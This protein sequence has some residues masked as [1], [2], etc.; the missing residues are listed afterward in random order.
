[1]NVL[2]VDDNKNDRKLLS[3]ILTSNN[4]KVNEVSNGIE[5]LKELEGSRPD[6]IISDI[7]M[8]KMDGFT[9]LREL[10]KNDD[11]KDIPFVYYTAYYVSEKDR[12]L[13]MKLGASRYILK[14]KEVKDLLSEIENVLEEYSDGKIKPF[15]PL[16]KSEEEYLTHY[17]ER[18]V[19]KLEEKIS[20]LWDTKNFLNA[21]LDNM[22]DGVMVTDPDLNIIYC[23]KRMKD[24]VSCDYYPGMIKKGAT[25][26]PCIPDMAH[27][28]KKPF[29]V[30][31]LNEE[32]K[33]VYLEGI[34]SPTIN[35]SGN[36]TSHIGVFR[37]ITDFKLSRE[38]I[39][40]K[41]REI[42]I[43]YDIDRMF[44]E[45]LNSDQLIE[46]ALN[47]VMEV[48]DVE[49]GCVYIVDDTSDKLKVQG[50]K[51]LPLKFVELI[52]DQSLDSL[53]VQNI[54]TSEKTVNVTKISERIQGLV[55]TEKEYGMANIITMQLRSREKIIGFI[56][57]M[58][59]PY[60]NITNNEISLLEKVGLHLGVVLENL[61]I[62]EKLKNTG[63]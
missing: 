40:R 58:V 38:D 60:R 52:Q 43:L 9:L 1:M 19:R 17:S 6:L 51:R 2:I 59:S 18:I 48:L 61:L 25:H 29:E 15:E 36:V 31:L 7:M 8:E 41:D 49:G 10:K 20:E 42:S 27:A 21:V 14:P 16:L 46:C 44:R 33:I 45:C 11:T 32:N 53:P 37:D 30:E 54:L 26:R 39:E 62:F 47:R 56:D 4:H 22:A 50:C 34:V 12:E 23:N 13:A 24:I 55:E 35:E 63:N 57:L 5:A 3:K 28:L